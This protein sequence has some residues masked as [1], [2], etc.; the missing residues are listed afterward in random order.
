[1]LQK[2]ELRDNCTASNETLEF[3][4]QVNMKKF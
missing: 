3:N 2:K 4:S 1:M